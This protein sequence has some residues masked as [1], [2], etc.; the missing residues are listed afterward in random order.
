MITL[1]QD[2]GPC[3]INWGLDFILVR[4]LL[5]IDISR[6]IDRS[7]T[8]EPAIRRPNICPLCSPLA[9]SGPGEA[10][11]NLWGYSLPMSREAFVDRA[12]PRSVDK[13]STCR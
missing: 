9:I 10:R 11:S 1:R 3:C 8:Q 7:I 13:L 12:I 2:S 6:Y 5:S 4:Y